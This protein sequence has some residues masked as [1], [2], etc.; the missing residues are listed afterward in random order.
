MK[1]M[2]PVS[3]IVPIQDDATKIYV[4]MTAIARSLPGTPQ[5]HADRRNGIGASEAA[6]ACGLDSY[7]QPRDLYEDKVNPTDEELN[8]IPIRIGHA[9]EDLVLSISAEQ[10]GH[11]IERPIPLFQSNRESW[12]LA[13]PDGLTG[14]G[15]PVDAKT[16][17]KYVARS[18]EILDLPDGSELPASA[19]SWNLQS[20]QQQYVVGADI[21]W[22]AVMILDLREVRTY[23]VRRD[24]DLIR[25]MLAHESDLWDRIQ[26][27]DPP[28]VDWSHNRCDDLLRRLFRD[29]T[30][31]HVVSASPAAAERWA[32][33]RALRHQAKVLTDEADAARRVVLAEMGEA[34]CM[35]LP[36]PE[37]GKR[38]MIK[39]S[40]IAE[41]EVSYLRKS[42]VTAR[43]V[44]APPATINLWT[45][46]KGPD[47]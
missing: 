26:R 43:E 3:N 17:V 42:Y 33:A 11:E 28:D 23:Y 4:S 9:L 29:V 14:G 10:S 38:K 15:A 16:T 22:I 8:T 32:R 31:D 34:A 21:G 27:R 18:M 12:C 24:D 35:L 25:M 30:V 13:T 7:R 20:Q 1:I 37:D 36:Q 6:A 41:T 46:S 19:A 45:A 44:N 47:E 5:W 40:R 2:I 39:R